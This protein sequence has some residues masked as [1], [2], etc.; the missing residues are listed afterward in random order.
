MRK[1]I[2][3]KTILSFLLAF[4]L[5]LSLIG[6]E[7]KDS[8]TFHTSE[9]H[10]K[11]AIINIWGTWCPPCR[12]ELPEFER[13]AKDFKDEVTVIAVHSSDYST[14]KPE[15]YVKENFPDSEIIFLWDKE[16]EDSEFDAFYAAV[17]GAGYYPFTVILDKHGRIIESIT[18]A[19]TY[20]RLAEEIKVAKLNGNI[21]F[22]P[23]SVGVGTEIGDLCP[24]ME[25]ERLNKE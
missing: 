22:D 2:I 9:L 25:L 3:L 12:N 14:I 4:S 13:I 16:S 5:I 17:G 15:D 8:K 11:V 18:G 6:C 19:T 23:N 7:K 1:N 24:T 21:E 10:G 20:E